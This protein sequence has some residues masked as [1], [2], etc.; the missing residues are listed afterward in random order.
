MS[1][2]WVSVKDRL[3]AE[4]VTVE[5]KIDDERGVRNEARLFLRGR[6]WWMDDGKMYV[7]YAPAHWRTVRS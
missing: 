2:E 1:D 6:L 3:P 7:Y 5:T 4:G